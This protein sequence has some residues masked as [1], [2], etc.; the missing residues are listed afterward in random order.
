MAWEVECRKPPMLL[1]M[2]LK[3]R[4]DE[5][6][7]RFLTGAQVGTLSKAAGCDALAPVPRGT[8][9][10]EAFIGCEPVLSDQTDDDPARAR[11]T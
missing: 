5:D 1:C 4:L 7:L 11:G 2:G 3:I 10:V 8:K 6:S 9:F